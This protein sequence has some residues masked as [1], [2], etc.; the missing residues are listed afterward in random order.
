MDG[1][2]AT[3]AQPVTRSV[4]VPSAVYSLDTIKKAAYK[5][6]DRFSVDPKPGNGGVECKLRFASG[7]T[8]QQADR[9]LADFNTELLDQDL[10]GK[11]AAETAPIRNAILALAFAP[12]RRSESE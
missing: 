9:I 11:I 2:P 8:E 4:Y 3:D 1:K 5:F 10:R 6:I 12:I 7:I